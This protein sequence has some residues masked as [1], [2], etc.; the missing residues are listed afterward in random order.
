M[1]TRTVSVTNCEVMCL[2]VSKAAVSTEHFKVTGAYD[3]AIDALNEVKRIYETDDFKPTAIVSMKVD[4][5]LYGLPEEKFIEIAEILPPRK[6][7][8][9][10]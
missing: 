7:Y 2:S 3:N 4:E 5:I 8:E 9:K 1:I 6:V 10:E